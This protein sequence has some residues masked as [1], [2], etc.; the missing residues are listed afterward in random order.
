MSTGTILS[1][2][3]LHKFYRYDPDTGDMWIAKHIPRSRSPVG[4]LVGRHLDQ[5][6]YKQVKIRGRTML[7]HR[8]IWTYMT[9]DPPPTVIDH[10]NRVKTDNRWVNLREATFRLNAINQTIDCN[11]TSGHKGSHFNRKSGKWHATIRIDGFKRFI[12]SYSTAQEAAMVYAVA[13]HY[14]QPHNP[15]AMNLPEQSAH[16]AVRHYLGRYLTDGT[17]D[18]LHPR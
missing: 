4:T 6:G 14:F 13:A 5:D 18:C 17:T 3:Y 16:R 1:H 11:N 10:I 15:D 8:V 12:G 9:G 7:L 2:E